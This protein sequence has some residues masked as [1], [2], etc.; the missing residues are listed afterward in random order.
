MKPIDLAVV[1]SKSGCHHKHKMGAAIYNKRKL[2]SIGINHSKTHPIQKRYS[3][4]NERS[5]QSIYLHA[6][7][8]AIIAAKG[9][10]QNS[11]IYVARWLR[12]NRIGDSRPCKACHNA[13]IDAGISKV[14]YFENGNWKT[15]KL[16]DIN[17]KFAES[18]GRM[19]KL[20][21]Y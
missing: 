20:D 6:E 19:K 13:L 17:W 15:E 11:H 14:T 7:I 2:I 5:D 10:T 12:S 16:K 9:S 21:I 1:A 4:D 18:T 8:A 3:V